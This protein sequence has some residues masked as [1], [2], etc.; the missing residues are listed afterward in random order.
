MQST[1]A[2]THLAQLH[3]TRSPAAQDQVQQPIR[4]SAAQVPR[5]DGGVVVMQVPETLM[6]KIR[7]FIQAENEVRGPYGLTVVIKKGGFRKWV[8]QIEMTDKDGNVMW[9]GSDPVTT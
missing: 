3:A 8:V 7:A 1:P 9:T 2:A 6:E 5:P 4:P